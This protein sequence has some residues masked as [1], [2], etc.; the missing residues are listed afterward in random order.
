[1]YKQTN[2]RTVLLK[3]TNA[4]FKNDGRSFLSLNER[5]DQTHTFGNAKNKN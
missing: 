3:L 5:N 4:K 1:M 2:N